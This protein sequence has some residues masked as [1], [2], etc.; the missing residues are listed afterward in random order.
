MDDAQ[1][2][3]LYQSRRCYLHLHNIST[4]L[5]LMKAYGKNV[6]CLLT[7]NSNLQKY[8]GCNDLEESSTQIEHN[9]SC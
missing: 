1:P 5:A 6:S 3:G 4:S 2:K 9:K 7:N 8:I